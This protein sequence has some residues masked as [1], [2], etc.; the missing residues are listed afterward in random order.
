MRLKLVVMAL[1]LAD[2]LWV[3]QGRFLSAPVELV[4]D[5]DTPV[6]VRLLDSLEDGSPVRGRV[7]FDQYAPGDEI[8]L[9]KGAAD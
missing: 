3:H 8:I 5:V 1:A 6:S 4:E 2:L 9:R 7:F